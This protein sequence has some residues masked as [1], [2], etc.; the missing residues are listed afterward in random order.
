MAYYNQRQGPVLKNGV[1]IQL[2][3]AF[4]E[5]NWP[6]V[7]R[8]ADKRA[9]LAHTPGAPPEISYYQVVKVCAETRLDG[10]SDKASAA[11]AI[12][13]WVRQ[14]PTT[15]PKDLEGID[16]L[17][18]ATAGVA[19]DYSAG[20]GALRARWAKANP[21]NSKGGLACLQKCVLQWD[22]V[23]AQQIAAILEKAAQ[24]GDRRFFFWNILLTHLLSVTPTQCAAESKR[25]IY[26]M[27]AQKQLEKA[28]SETGKLADEEEFLFYFRVLAAHG[29]VENY[30]QRAMA[31]EA[32]GVTK[33]FSAAGR[34]QLLYEVLG[35]LE[36]SK[37]WTAVFNICKDVLSLTTDDDVPS[38]LACDMRIWNSFIAAAQQQ[39]DTEGAF[40][41]V[42]AL[43]QAFVAAKPKLPALHAKNISIALLQ[44]VA[45]MPPSLMPQ[46][47]LVEQLVIFIEAN[48]DRASVFG[49]VKKYVETLS[50][51]D[52]RDLL[53]KLGETRDSLHRDVLVLKLRYLLA[54]CPE[55]RCARAMLGGMTPAAADIDETK[56]FEIACKVC[57]R[58]APQLYGCTACLEAIAAPSLQL[59]RQ[60]SSGEVSPPARVDKD[61]RVDLALVA[62][63][64]LVRLAGVHRPKSSPCM[65]QPWLN[66]ID[67][68]RLLQ[69]A[70]VLNTQHSLTPDDI[71][72]RLLLVRVLLVLGSAPRALQ[73]WQPLG[74][75]RTILDALGPLFYD[76]LS[77]VAPGLFV[78]T[79][80]LLEP[81]RQYFDN[82]LRY[83]SAVKVW[84]AFASGSYSS[85]LDMADFQ[86]NL[87]NSCTRAMTVVEERRAARSFGG[88]LDDVQDAAIFAREYTDVTLVNVTDYGSL[89]NL[90]S[91][92]QTPLGQSVALGPA[93]SSV[94][95]Q[96]GLLAERFLDVINFKAAKEYKPSKPAD[97]AARERVFLQESLAVLQF[98]FDTLLQQ[99]VEH[100]L[101]PAEWT[102]FTVVS[103]LTAFLSFALGG[104]SP[105]IFAL[106]A[107]TVASA[108]DI[109]RAA[110]FVLV[111]DSPVLSTMTNL[112]ALGMLRD[113]AVA[114]KQTSVFVAVF[115]DREL[116][117]DRTGKSGLGKEVLAEARAYKT[118]WTQL[119]SQIKAHIKR[120]R[121]SIAAFSTKELV[122]AAQG[123]DPLSAAIFET[124][125]A[126]AV[127]E[128]A[129][130]LVYDW[131]ETIQGWGQVQME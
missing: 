77:T 48:M 38:T 129:G 36:T 90:E 7:I 19:L 122:A 61:L 29:T 28:A 49:D 20:I 58:P 109:L 92:S 26:G 10:I 85:I 23:N 25:K 39:T 118:L 12:D 107:K 121:E 63:S 100:E 113:T 84:D 4:Q 74:V 116:A 126:S 131:I 78:G 102:Y 30:L 37:Q 18:W 43:L 60:L 55:T 42:Q 81:L 35:Q 66:G 1:D 33:Q 115:Q 117:R 50:F 120:S 106:L 98:S 31:D 104:G 83:P 16:L 15:T 125:N 24:A 40:D 119:L 124:I 86:Q 51:G 108:V 34:K 128:W 45:S 65:G 54:T 96:L 59:H 22:L 64:C 9:K 123:D 53:K 11:V 44:T 8:L 69:A 21:R 73:L 32:K 17:E 99:G 79:K 110:V 70:L 46:S 130:G 72:T 56:L 52:A 14:S 97:A 127:D 41:A 89:P 88:K 91:S 101:T 114:V 47:M 103:S 95:M 5:Q 71:P 57:S 67:R 27:L 111:P 75:K 105:A 6:V 62:A 87:E 112:H 82:V 93:L 94:R 80:P 3:S 76:R 68:A 2:Q 13:A